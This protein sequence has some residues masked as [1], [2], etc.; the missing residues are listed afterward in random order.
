[1]RMS[2][3]ASIGRRRFSHAAA[4]CSTSSWLRLEMYANCSRGVSPSA[5]RTDSPVSSRRFS[6][7]TRTM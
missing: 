7:A 3:S 2:C 4:C 6:P 5:L 1:M